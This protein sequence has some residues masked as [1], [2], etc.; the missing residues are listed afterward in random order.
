MTEELR[1]L[2]DRHLLAKGADPALQR[3]AYFAFVG[4]GESGASDVAERHD[5]YLDEAFRGARLR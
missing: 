3:E 2:I 1:R 4:I 5:D